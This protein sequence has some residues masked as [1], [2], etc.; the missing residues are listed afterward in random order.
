MLSGHCRAVVIVREGGFNDAL[1]SDN[2]GSTT[3]SVEHKTEP[4]LLTERELAGVIRS[5]RG[6]R[7]WSQETLAALSGLSVRTVQR[8]EA[9]GAAERDTRRALARALE[10]D[11][12]DAFNKPYRI[13]TTQELKEAQEDFDRTHLTLD[14]T[15]ATTGAE[16]GRLFEGSTADVTDMSVSMDRE[17]AETVAQVIDYLRDY[18]DI[19]A[20]Y[21]EMEKLDVFD[22]LQRLVDRLASLGIS[23]CYAAR[24]M[25]VVGSNCVDKTPMPVK[26]AYVSPVKKGA[27]P[28][29]LVVSKPI[30]LG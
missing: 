7:R 19:A 24:E 11:D 14:A 5:L 10:F 21:G 22:D 6:M 23:L 27:E 2:A 13:P 25:T 18:R 26:L 29:K 8:V 4:R 30:R 1:G 17:A 12:I 16:L 28:T 9:S 20:D 3:M 15:I